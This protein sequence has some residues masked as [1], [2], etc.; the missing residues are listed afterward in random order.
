MNNPKETSKIAAAKAAANLIQN[1]MKVGLGT[2]STAGFFI[3]NLIERCRSKN[4]KIKAVATSERSAKQAQEGG[5]PL[6]DLNDLKTLDVTVDGADEI[7]HKKRMIKGGGGALLREKII[8]SHSKEMII[9]IDHEK[10][11]KNLG[12]FPLP[13]EVVPFACEATL[14]KILQLG[15]N[16]SFRMTKKNKKYV[17]DNN[18]FIID[19]NFSKEIEHPERDNDI[20]RAIPGI[21][22]TGFFL[23][24]A[25]RVIIGYPDG[26]VD[27][28]I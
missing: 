6:F 7:D 8:A 23:D 27:I 2:G 4:L 16:G 5:I 19:I 22:D 17:T 18:N 20:L 28:K 10:L 21:V 26:H 25:G 3:A 9:I 1:G 15:Y 14:H 13:L 12:G 11:V 24:M